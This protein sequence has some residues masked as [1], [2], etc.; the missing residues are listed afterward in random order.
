MKSLPKNSAEV[1]IHIYDKARSLGIPARIESSLVPHSDSRYVILFPDTDQEAVIRV[2]S[3]KPYEDRYALC[4]DVH[5]PNLLATAPHKANAW[6][7][8]HYK[9]LPKASPGVKP[10]RRK[11]ALGHKERAGGLTWRQLIER[12][13]EKEQGL[14]QP[15]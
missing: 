10:K 7:D 6:L 4:I 13:Q 15:E 14:V 2:S 9:V 1:V 11:K 3:H 8:E 5:T 12:E